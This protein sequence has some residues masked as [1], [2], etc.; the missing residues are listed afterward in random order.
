MVKLLIEHG[1]A[2][3]RDRQS[4]GP[5]PKVILKIAVNWDDLRSDLRRL[6]AGE[7]GAESDLSPEGRRRVAFLREAREAMR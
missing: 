3:T 2:S 5:K 7:L 4:S 1:L 6:E